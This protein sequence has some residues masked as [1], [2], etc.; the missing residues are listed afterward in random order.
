MLGRK[1]NNNEESSDDLN[2]HHLLISRMVQELCTFLCLDYF[3][4]LV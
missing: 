2:D 1:C 4:Y 3:T